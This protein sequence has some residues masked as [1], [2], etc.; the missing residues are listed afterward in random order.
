MKNQ[1]VRGARPVPKLP[2][3]LS[4]MSKWATYERHK[5]EWMSFHP[6]HT[7]EQYEKAIRNIA[8]RLYL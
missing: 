5:R 6:N 8:R 2:I 7:A 1:P 4:E 3:A